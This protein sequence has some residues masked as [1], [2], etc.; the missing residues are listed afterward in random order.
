MPELIVRRFWRSNEARAVRCFKADFTAMRDMLVQHCKSVE[1]STKKFKYLPDELENQTSEDRVSSMIFIG[2]HPEIEVVFD[3]HL[4]AVYH[5]SDDAK[6]VSLSEALVG[7]LRQNTSWH[8]RSLFARGI[9]PILAFVVV[10]YIGAVILNYL[11][12]ETSIYYLFGT[13]MGLMGI[14]YLAFRA[15]GMNKNALYLRSL[16]NEVSWIRKNQAWVAVLVQL[17]A[18]AIIAEIIHRLHK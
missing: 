5:Y 3:G 14:F 11:P 9:P 15:S 13:Q 17:S 8:Q 7:F 1:I 4:A 6:G 2:H 16:E 12:P 10:S 18:G